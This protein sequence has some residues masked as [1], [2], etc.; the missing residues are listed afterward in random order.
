MR[1][2][3]LCLLLACS[4]APEPSFDRPAEEGEPTKAPTKAAGPT[5]PSVAEEEEAPRPAART[6]PAP[7][8]GTAPKAPAIGQWVRYGVT[9][10]EGGR[11]TVEYRIVDREGDSWWLEITDRRR[12]RL[13]EVRMRIRPQ[14]DGT[15]ELLALTFKNGRE[16]EP[17]PTRLLGN[18]APMLG[19]WLDTMLRTE[20]SGPQEDVTVAAGTFQGAFKGEQTMR[21]LQAEITADVWWHPEVPVT[22]MVKLVDRAE[23]GH[24]LELLGWGDSGAVSSF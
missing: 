19:Q 12:D 1:V 16:L 15:K 5:R 3:L 11:S 8:L 2:S 21:F 13:R 23:G 4:S 17:V 6:L 24:N 22:A 7:A 20:V 9:Y 18:Y 10:R 14:P